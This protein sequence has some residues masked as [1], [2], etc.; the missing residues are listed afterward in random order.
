MTKVVCLYRGL[1]VPSP[2][3]SLSPTPEEHV[4]SLTVLGNIGRSLPAFDSILDVI[5]DV[6]EV[7]KGLVGHIFTLT[8]GD[9]GYVRVSAT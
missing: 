4:I 1:F 6:A 2:V 7:S 3:H 8:V 9:Q 5:E